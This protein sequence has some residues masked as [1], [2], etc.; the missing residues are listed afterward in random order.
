MGEENVRDPGGR[1]DPLPLEALVRLPSILAPKLAWKGDRVAFYWDRTGRN[2]LFVQSIATG[3]V[4]QVSHGEVPRSVKVGLAWD[5]NDEFV[6]FGKD[7]E[8]NEKHDLYRMEVAGGEVTRLTSVGADLAPSDIS[9]DNRWLLFVATAPGRGGRRQ[10]NAWRVP[11]A[12]GEAEQVTDFDAPVGA[13]GAVRYRADGRALGFSANESPDLRNADLYVSG[14]EGDGPTRVFRAREGSRDSFSAWH[15]DGQ[16]IA[17]D[18][19]ASGVTRP[20]VLD[21]RSGEVRTFGDGRSDEYAKSFSSDGRSLLTVRLDG[22]RLG[23]RLYDLSSGDAVDLP[24][25]SGDVR[26]LDFD[27]T[28]T[29]I[30]GLRTSSTEPTTLVRLGPGPDQVIL[31]PADYGGIDPGRLT[32][33]AVVG[34]RAPDGRS[35]EAL[36]YAPRGRSAGRRVPAILE[37]H[38]G[39]TAHFSE[40]FDPLA[41]HFASRGFAVLQPNVRGSTGYGPDF[42]DLNRFDWGG[43]DLRDVV[44]AAEYLRGLP[45]VDPDRLGV[46]GGSYGG[47]LTYMAVVRHPGLWGAACAWIGMTDLESLYDGSREHFQYYLRQQMGDPATHRALWRQRSA[48]HEAHRLRARLLIVHGVN[49]PRCPI[50]QA[51]AFRDRLLGAGRVLGRDFEYLELPEGHGSSDVEQK[52]RC[53]ATVAEFFA[54]AL[55]DPERSGEGVRRPS[56]QGPPASF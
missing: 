54:R 26:P 24:P 37:L 38:G 30:I 48:I 11:I 41:Q 33:V 52:L 28:G 4:R 45:Y 7:E 8:G 3:D 40:R 20:M 25:A 29:G 47:Y 5:R 14:P 17:F 18:S 36:L 44:A 21:R 27:A 53:Y 22:V 12:G 56:A 23:P 15:P 46:W 16:Q 35:I 50:D 43:G 51:R 49:D 39:P 9:P 31:R 2:E 1:L 42:R 32:E 6:I 19:D 10:L 34:Y 13:L 55:G